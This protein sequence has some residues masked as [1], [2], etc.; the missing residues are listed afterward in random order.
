MIMNVRLLLAIVLLSLTGC[1][2]TQGTNPAA[3]NASTP[4]WTG[5]YRGYRLQQHHSWQRGR[6]IRPAKMATRP[7]LVP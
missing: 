2:M 7:T 3:R 1:G 6:N 4:G 5:L